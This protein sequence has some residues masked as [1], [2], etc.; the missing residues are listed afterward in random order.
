MKILLAVI[1]LCIATPVL[2]HGIY[3]ELTKDTICTCDSAEQLC[4]SVE[5][6]PDGKGNY[7]L[8]V[9]GETIP[10]NQA[11]SSP[12]DR[13]HRCTWPM[14]VAWH[15]AHKFPGAQLGRWVV[16]PNNNTLDGKPRTRCFFAPVVGW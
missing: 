4:E 12:D 14:N 3:T 2:A 15:G 9:S 13:F 8:P 10:A 11:R 5:A 1:A 6:V 16:V 7:Y